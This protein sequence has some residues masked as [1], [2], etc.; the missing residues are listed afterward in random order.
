M[1]KP[2]PSR[3]S[4]DKL[5]KYYFSRIPE[6]ALAKLYYL[7]TPCLSLG[8]I[9]LMLNLEGTRQGRNSQFTQTLCE[10]IFS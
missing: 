10:K 1:D 9:I 5:S 2:P 7:E 3:R 6:T 8:E 4:P